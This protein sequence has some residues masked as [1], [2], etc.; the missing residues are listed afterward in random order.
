MKGDV[1]SMSFGSTTPNGVQFKMAGR[2][3]G[4]Q[5]FMT[6]NQSQYCIP[7]GQTTA[8]FIVGIHDRNSEPAMSTKRLIDLPPGFAVNVGIRISKIVRNTE[9]WPT[10]KCYSHVDMKL[11]PST[12]EYRNSDDWRRSCLSYK[13][14]ENC[15][16][17]QYYTPP[18]S[19]STLGI[20]FAEAVYCPFNMSTFMC[21]TH[22]EFNAIRNRLC[23]NA[24]TP[25]PC[26]EIKYKTEVT[27]SKFPSSA[28]FNEF[29]RLSNMPASMSMEEFRRNFLL[30]NF[31]PLNM[32]TGLIT[33]S[34]EFTWIDLMNQVGGALGISLGI[35]I[36]SIFEVFSWIVLQFLSLFQYCKR[37]PAVQ[38]S[39]YSYSVY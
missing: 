19:L 20:N 5:L 37:Q 18:L 35:S 30:V 25:K 12:K 33:Y 26:Y 39:H 11:Y 24:D 38:M 2:R 23:G 4:F 29:K 6:V 36:I 31:F 9:N 8:E 13:I 17:F 10:E 15:G 22:F 27:S 34:P 14:W 1:N 16:C 32:D 3:G 28:Q 21:S 7:A